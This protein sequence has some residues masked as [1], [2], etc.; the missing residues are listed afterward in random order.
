MRLVDQG[1]GQMGVVDMVARA[2]AYVVERRQR[3][4]LALAHDHFRVGRAGPEAIV[5]RADQHHRPR[6]VFHRNACAFDRGRIARGAQEGQG[7]AV[8]RRG[9]VRR[10][11]IRRG[12]VLP[13]MRQ[14]LALPRPYLGVA[15]RAR[16]AGADHPMHDRRRHIGDDGAHQFGIVRGHQQGG[17]ASAADARHGD[18]AVAR[19]QGLAHPLQR[20]LE[21]F[22]RHVV[23]VLG[24]PVVVEDRQRQALVAARGE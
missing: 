22:Q 15:P 19:L 5:R 14:W 20:R 10:F 6:V 21:V 8:W 13:Q 16:R 24:T 2:R 11:P 3:V 7:L 12:I 17:L 1:G 23:Q 4:R 9:R 18:E